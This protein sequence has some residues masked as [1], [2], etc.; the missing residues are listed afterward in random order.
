VHRAL[1]YKKEKQM[2]PKKLC[3]VLIP[4]LA[5]LFLSA[6]PLRI[7]NGEKL[8]YRIKY[9]GKE[10]I[11]TI[12]Y[13]TILKNKKQYFYYESYGPFSQLGPNK[14]V[15]SHKW[16]VLTDRNGIP[17]KINFFAGK[18]AVKMVFNGKGNVN[19]IINWEGKFVKKS[20]RF[21][22]NVTL[23]NAL[24]VRT[25]D[26]SRKNKYIFDLLQL[27]EMPD[28]EAYEMFFKVIGNKTV[29]VKAGTFRC[30]KIL[31][32]LT[33]FRGAFYKAYYYVTDDEHR[34]TVKIDNVPMNGSTELI[35]IKK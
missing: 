28:L 20:K 17:R 4:L 15:G 9:K 7:R 21:K 12:E 30:K 26:L 13:K 2:K 22:K 34:Y 25:L 18:D 14:H 5:L 29:T 24:V 31:F 8:I 33:G 32:S 1:F 16:E 11:Q 10:Y 35:N 19:V 3:S 23:E 6:S 27:R